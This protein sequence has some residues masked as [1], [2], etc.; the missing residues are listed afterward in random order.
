M[1]RDLRKYARRTNLRLVVG[2]ILLILVI[3]VGLI[4]LFYDLQAALLGLVCL[5]SG[6]TILLM[7]WL[8]LW[9]IEKIVHR[10]NQ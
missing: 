4:Y 1:S 6:I 3:G 7:I 9:A 5:L 8:S 10:A 2:G